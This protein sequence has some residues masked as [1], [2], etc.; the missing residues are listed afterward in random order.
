MGFRRPVQLG[1]LFIALLVS[2]SITL[3]QEQG[4]QGPP[5]QPTGNGMPNDRMQMMHQQM[6]PLYGNV[7]SAR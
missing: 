2:G 6:V 5:K 1:V 7:P 3:A 4:Q